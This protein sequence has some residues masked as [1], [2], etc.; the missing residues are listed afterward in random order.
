[1]HLLRSLALSVLFF[2][3]IGLTIQQAGAQERQPYTLDQ[4]VGLLEARLSAGVILEMVR[5]DCV[6]FRIDEDAERVLSESGA[7]PYLIEGLRSVCYRGPEPEADPEEQAPVSVEDPPTT[8][9]LPYN[10]GS[11]GLRSLAIP[12]LGQFY[13]GR[14]AVGAAFLAAW[15]GAIGFGLL[16]QE[17]TVECL[18][19]TTGA[20]P[21]DMVL[22]ESVSRNMLPVGLGAAAAIAIISAFEARSGANKA[23]ARQ[24]VLAGGQHGPK[25]VL[26]LLPFSQAASGSGRV[27]LQLRHR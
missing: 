27:L 23:N 19:Q 18:A 9:P 6:V 16:S 8:Q 4:L 14:P 22:S 13:T 11:A 5:S 12:G 21:S 26:D 3:A 25:L 17:T 20:C 15:A 2:S 1:M 24:M 10:P 7:T